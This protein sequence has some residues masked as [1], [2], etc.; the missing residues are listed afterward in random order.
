MDRMQALV[1]ISEYSYI[2]LLVPLLIRG[3]PIAVQLS[4]RQ[5]K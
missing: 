4:V 5:A 1:L 2:M 3:T